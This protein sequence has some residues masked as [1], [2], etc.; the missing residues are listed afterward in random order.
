VCP[1]GPRQVG[2]TEASAALPHNLEAAGLPQTWDRR[3]D[4]DEGQRFLDTRQL[5]IQPR[6]DSFLAERAAP[7]LPILVY[8]EGCREVRD[9]REVQD[10]EPTNGHPR[11]DPVGA[12]ENLIDLLRNLT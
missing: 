3:R 2:Q 9:V 10:R 11:S 1:S 8:D 5:A 6:H 4:D 12:P 7:L